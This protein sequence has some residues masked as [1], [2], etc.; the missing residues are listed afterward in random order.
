MFHLED[1]VENYKEY[2]IKSSRTAKLWL[3]YIYY[4]DVVKMLIR[5]EKCGYWNLHVVAISKMLKLLAA[6]RIINYAKSSRLHL[7]NML[8]L[9]NSHTWVYEQFTEERLNIVRRNENLWAWLWTDLIIK[10][11]MM[12]SIKS[13]SRLTR[14]RG[15]T[16]STRQLWIGSMHRCAEIHNAIGELTGACPNTSE[17]H[18]GLSCSQ[19]MR[20]NNDFQTLK[21]L[22]DKDEPRLKSLLSGLIGDGAINCDQAEETRRKIQET[23]D[24]FQMEEASIKRKDKVR[25]FE[26]LML[27]TKIDHKDVHI[28]PTIFFSSLTASAC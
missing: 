9:K 3:L 4:F 10:Q 19:I 22:F 18:V 16:E 1:I 5:A 20:D 26:D 12:R 23:I 11:V 13:S 8:N 27:T 2:L 6:T 14:G 25:N 28:D 15:I 21:N 24:G 17:Q 7:E